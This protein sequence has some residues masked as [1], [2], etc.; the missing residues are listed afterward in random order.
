MQSSNKFYN[1]HSTSIAYVLPMI[2]LV[3]SDA[4]F[5]LHAGVISL[6][7]NTLRFAVKDWK[8][9]IALKTLRSRVRDIVNAAWKNPGKP[10]GI[11]EEKWM[12]LFV[13]VFD[14]EQEKSERIEKAKV[15]GKGPER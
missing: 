9:M 13:R 11:R 5:R 14:L 7:N 2:L 15:K 6:N 10:L 8:T 12:R 4:D 1:A 3:G